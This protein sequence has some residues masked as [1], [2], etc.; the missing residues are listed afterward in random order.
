VHNP[1]CSDSPCGG[2][3]SRPGRGGVLPA[4]SG[5]V[6]QGEEGFQLGQ[7]GQTLLGQEGAS[8]SADRRQEIGFGRLFAASKESY[9]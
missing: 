4:E 3:L 7:L 6:D 2:H 5:S 1:D 8:S 9:R